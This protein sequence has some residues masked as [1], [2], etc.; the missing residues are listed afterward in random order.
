MPQTTPFGV[1]L[2]DLIAKVMPVAIALSLIV[3][4]LEASVSPD[5]EEALETLLFSLS[6]FN[7]VELALLGL[8]FLLVGEIINIVRLA[9]MPVPPSFHRLFLGQRNGR[10]RFLE[11]LARFVARKI[12]VFGPSWG[13][14]EY[15]ELTEIEQQFKTTFEQHYSWLTEAT[16]SA[17]RYKL[18]TGY[19][20]SHMS[21]RTRDFRVLYQFSFNGIIAFFWIFF[22][23]GVII[24]VNS[25]A[26]QG[27]VATGV[28]AFSTFGIPFI[29][30]MALFSFFERVYVHS[31]LLEYL[32]YRMETDHDT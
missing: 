30:F 10:P 22:P 28:R 9:I 16:T 11:P 19:I 6:N 25:V 13:D 27:F 3:G 21:D 14:G 20:G 17:D 8:G 24:Q 1:T 23:S 18:L 5:Q 7:A 26:S 4:T 32:S 15:K 31:L 29:V 2:S 12:W